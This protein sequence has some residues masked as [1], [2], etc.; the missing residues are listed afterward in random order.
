MP[1]CELRYGFR[2]RAHCGPRVAPL[3]LVFAHLKVFEMQ[4]VADFDRLDALRASAKAAAKVRG[5]IHQVHFLVECACAARRNS[6]CNKLPHARRP[7]S[8]GGSMGMNPRSQPHSHR[9]VIVGSLMRL[10]SLRVISAP[11]PPTPA[12]RPPC[13]LYR[14]CW[15]PAISS[16]SLEAGD[17]FDVC[18]E[19]PPWPR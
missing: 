17:D 7:L 13:P 12:T 6:P 19:S 2:G 1:A 18:A 4:I 9:E 15:S 11:P 16:R 14:V 10:C 8:E 3:A 5:R